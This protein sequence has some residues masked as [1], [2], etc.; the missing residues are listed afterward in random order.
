[1]ETT[2]IQEVMERLDMLEESIHKL[3]GNVDALLVARL[4]GF[5][6]TDSSSSL[7]LK[8]QELIKLMREVDG[9]ETFLGEFLEGVK[10]QIPKG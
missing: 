5:D 6:A 1:M 10:S 9:N 8:E 4:A 3:P 7:S 2:Q